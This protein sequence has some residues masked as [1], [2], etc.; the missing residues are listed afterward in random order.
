ML[1]KEALYLARVKM[2]NYMHNRITPIAGEECEIH[3]YTG[4]DR[5]ASMLEEARFRD[6][7]QEL[8]ASL[9]RDTDKLT[10]SRITRA[11]NVVNRALRTGKL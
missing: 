2:F 6:R 10:D 9:P 3:L 4:V 1:N 11:V 8:R 7:A 5:H